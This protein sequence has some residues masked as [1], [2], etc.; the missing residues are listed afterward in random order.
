MLYVMYKYVKTLLNE[1]FLSGAQD[2]L[3]FNNRLQE[4]LQ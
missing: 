3:G 2:E 4:K 1:H